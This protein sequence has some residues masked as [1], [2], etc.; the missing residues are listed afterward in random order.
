MPSIQYIR[1]LD[2][3]YL[4]RR[5]A[6]KENW[7]LEEAQ[8]AVRRYK[9]F[10]ILRCKYPHLKGA[11]AE[12]I[13]A[14]WHAHILHTREYTEDC[15]K[16]FGIYLHHAPARGTEGEKELLEEKYKQYAELYHKEF[17]ELYSPNID[18]STFW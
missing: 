9:N 2:L 7:V 3:E 11:P 10:L 15:N 1:K 4:A 8:E 5:L 6:F 17:N 12:D 14:V 16:M 18:V 13:D